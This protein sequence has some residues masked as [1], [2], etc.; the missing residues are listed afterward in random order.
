MARRCK[1][2]HDGQDLFIQ[3]GADGRPYE[4]TKGEPAPVAWRC[5]RCD[6]YAPL[7]PSNDTPAAMVELRAAEVAARYAPV[8]EQWL[9]GTMT[10]CERDGW[11]NAFAPDWAPTGLPEEAGALARYIATHEETT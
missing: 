5:V 2:R 4:A 10:D 11:E 7:G 1:H 9:R 8:T 6:E 3:Y